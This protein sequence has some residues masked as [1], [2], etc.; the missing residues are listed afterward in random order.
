M[1]HKNT[2]LVIIHFNIQVVRV[3]LNGP[4]QTEI[5]RM[6]TLYFGMYLAQTIFL[7]QKTGL[8]CQLKELVFI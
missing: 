2:L 7:E 4:K 6:K 5:L 3:Y 8:L 1:S